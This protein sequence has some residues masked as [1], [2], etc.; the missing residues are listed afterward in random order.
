[1]G[2]DTGADCWGPPRLR[3]SALSLI[4]ARHLPRC[5]AVHVLALAYNTPRQEQTGAACYGA[6]AGELGCAHGHVAGPPALV[7]AP[8]SVLLATREPA[9]HSTQ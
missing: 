6:A 8:C 4:R 1:M 5:S 3:L 7:L 9:E 2:E